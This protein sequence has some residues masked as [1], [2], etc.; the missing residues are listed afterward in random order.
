[1]IDPKFPSRAELLKM[2][3]VQLGG[4]RIVDPEEESLV[5]SVIEEKNATNPAKPIVDVFDMDLKKIHITSPEQ[6]K[7]IQ[8]ELDKRRAGG[9]VSEIKEISLDEP[10]VETP[11]EPIKGRKVYC[12]VCGSKSPA[13]HKKGCATKIVEPRLDNEII[14]SNALQTASAN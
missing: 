9:V 12:E 11:K 1:M 13:F 8:A 4:L 6:E 2:T 5:Q 14:E 10:V 3:F 7:M